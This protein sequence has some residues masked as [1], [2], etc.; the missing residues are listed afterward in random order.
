MLCPVPPIRA[1]LLAYSWLLL[2]LQIQILDLPLIS[3][4]ARSEL[5]LKTLTQLNITTFKFV[6]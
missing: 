4:L 6:A 1:L 5:I 2:S 3:I